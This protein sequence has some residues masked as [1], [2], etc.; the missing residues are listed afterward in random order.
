MTEENEEASQNYSGMN[1]FDL[2]EKQ[3]VIKDRLI[4][5]GQNLIDFKEESEKE[6]LEIKKDVESM[7]HLLEKIKNLIETISEEISGFA[8]KEDLD[9]LKKQAKMFQPLEFVK[10][11]DLKNLKT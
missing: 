2:E 7:K 3:R 11:S 8:K 10:K 4:L 1:L 5:V 6:I 9:I